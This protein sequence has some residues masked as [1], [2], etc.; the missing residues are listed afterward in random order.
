VQDGLYIKV[1]LRDISKLACGA[2]KRCIKQFGKV[3]CRHFGCSVE[4]KTIEE[5]LEHYFN[6]P[7]APKKVNITQGLDV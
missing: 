3:S 6:C 1:E 5:T 7:M 4:S 2:M